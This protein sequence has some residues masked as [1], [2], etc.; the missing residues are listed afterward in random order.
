MIRLHAQVDRFQKKKEK[1][2]KSSH[3][4]FSHINSTHNYFF[5]TTLWELDGEF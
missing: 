1:K 5:Y 2:K 3:L 4:R